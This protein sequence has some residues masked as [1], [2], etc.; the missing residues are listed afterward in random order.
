MKLKV[1]V[2]LGQTNLSIRWTN[3]LDGSRYRYY[4]V[5]G[6]VYFVFN[7][8]LRLFCESILVQYAIAFAIQLTAKFICHIVGTWWH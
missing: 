4:R 1:S 7:L 6:E 3:W 2:K 5:M 8:I